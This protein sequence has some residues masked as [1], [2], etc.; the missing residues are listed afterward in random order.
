MGDVKHVSEKNPNKRSYI[1]NLTL[2]DALRA[3]MFG[4]L[5]AI[6]NDVLKMPIRMP[7]HTSIYWMGILILGKGLIKRHGCGIVMGTISGI[8]A[9]AL[10]IG[11]EGIFV[12]FKYFT[13]GLLLDVLAPLYLYKLEKPIVAAI[14]GG[15]I[16]L[17]K[18]VASIIIG[19]ILNIPL[20]FLTLGL[21]Y[22]AISHVI[23]GALGG[24]IASIGIK[25]LKTKLGNWD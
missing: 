18:L 4:V 11:K 23:F 24:V 6:V 14:C 16:S 3:T 5:I 8:L 19:L 10:G 25:R 12:F 1:F 15:L 20:L 21:S 7:G 2:V 9:V 13:P 17:S 22:V